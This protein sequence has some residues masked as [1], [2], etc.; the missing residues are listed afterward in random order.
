M[1]KLKELLKAAMCNVSAIQTAAEAI[2]ADTIGD[3][4]EATAAV[5]AAIIDALEIPKVERTAAQVELAKAAAEAMEVVRF[6][7]LPDAA[8][9]N[10]NRAGANGVTLDQAH[11]RLLKAIDAAGENVDPSAACFCPAGKRIA[12]GKAKATP[13]PW[14]DAIQGIMAAREAVHHRQHRVA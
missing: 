8:V 12:Y 7:L 2:N 13:K 9:T 3:A 1:S 4:D 5:N 11:R 14:H 6:H 10:R